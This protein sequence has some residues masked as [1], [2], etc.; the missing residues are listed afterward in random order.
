MIKLGGMQKVGRALL[1]PIAVMPAAAL[2]LRLGSPDIVA[3][4]GI[5]GMHGMAG[6]TLRTLF[7]VMGAAGGAIFNNLPML[8]AVGVAIGL[9]D[10]AGV[11]AL[12][13]VIGYFILTT[14]FTNMT[15]FL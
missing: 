14:V 11:S 2:L 4:L 8:F 7:S 10:G 13:A 9:A 15:P 5:A 6:E 3:K 1:V 12:A